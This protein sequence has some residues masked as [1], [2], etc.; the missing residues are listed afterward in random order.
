MTVMLTMMYDIIV[1]VFENLPF[2]LLTR[3]GYKAGVFN[4][5][6]PLRLETVFEN[7]RFCCLNTPFTCGR[8]AKTGEKIAIFKNIRIRVEGT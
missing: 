5:L 2:S 8:K 6:T 7:L 4:K 1:I 3:K